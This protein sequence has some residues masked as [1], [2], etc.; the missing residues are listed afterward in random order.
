MGHQIIRQPDGRLAV[1][2]TIVD[3]FIYRDMSAEQ[4]IDVLVEDERGKIRKWVMEV[5]DLLDKGGKPYHQFT[6][7]WEEAN[8]LR[9]DCHGDV[10]LEEGE[11]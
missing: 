6:M 1:W 11:L 4:M 9:E 7:S 5:C 2:S 10:P 3:D 8:E